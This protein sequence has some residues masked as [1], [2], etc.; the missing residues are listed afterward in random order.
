MRMKVAG[1]AII[2]AVAGCV[3]P[4]IAARASWHA[5]FDGRTLAGWEETPFGGEGQ[6]SVRDGRIVLEFGEPLTGITW[7]GPVPRINYEVRL[8][9]MKLAGSDFFCAL[10]F[11]VG[12]SSCS[13]VLGGWGGSTVGLSTI[14]GLDAS[15]NETTQQIAFDDNRWYAVRVR[16]TDARITAWLDDRPIVDVATA[17]RKIGIRPEVD[18]SRPLG[19]ASYRTRAAL[20]GIEV[21]TIE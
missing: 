17:G 9:A 14:D 8:E 2:F 4:V 20:R 19:I 6:I 21:R 18:L 3:W 16:V 10:T 5:L 15:E 7:R 11:P 12:D 1:A 13:L